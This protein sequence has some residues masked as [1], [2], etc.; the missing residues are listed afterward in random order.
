MLRLAL[1]TLPHRRGGSFAA[2]IVLFGVAALLVGCGLL[3]QTGL[4][5]VVAPERYAAAPI[6]IV[7]DQNAHAVDHQGGKIKTKSKPLAERV[8]IPRDVA[9]TVRT[10]PGVQA[11]QA[12]VGFPADLVIDGQPV[13]GPGGSPS[14]G[15]GWE[16]ASLTPF[17]LRAGRAPAAADEIV[18]DAALADRTGVRVG[19]TVIVQATTSPTRYRVVGVAAPGAVG[20]AAPGARSDGLR[21]QSAVFFSSTQARL[22]AGRPGQIAALGVWPTPGTDPNALAE[23]LRHTLADTPV[24]VTTG[25]DRGAAEFP[26]GADAKARVVSMS[27]VLGGTALLVAILVVAG[28]IVLSLQRRHREFALLRTIGATPG[29][30]RAMIGRESLLVGS[31]RH[32]PDVSPA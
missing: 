16:S 1:S 8:W 31:S 5:G 28:T 26:Q 22:L 11:V 13:Q 30:I 7:G 10:M 27:G 17:L 15:H 32:C 19:S 4:A 24:S 14:W 18:V 23:N 9:D 12:E 6:I 20:V 29:Q 25:T 3:L 2:L 21:S